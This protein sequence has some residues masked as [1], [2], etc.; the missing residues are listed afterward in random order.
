MTC[1]GWMSWHFDFSEHPDAVSGEK[2]ALAFEAYYTVIFA[3]IDDAQGGQVGAC[4]V[5]GLWPGGPLIE[6]SMLPTCHLLARRELSTPLNV[7]KKIKW[8]RFIE[9]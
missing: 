9:F 7:R 2:T 1:V 5:R 3:S 6:W 4:G 8:G